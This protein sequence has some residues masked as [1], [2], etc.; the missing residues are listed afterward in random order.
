MSMEAVVQFWQTVERTP[1]LKK[2]VLLGNTVIKFEQLSL[3][4]NEAGF[5]CTQDELRAADNVTRFWNRVLQDKTLQRELMPAEELSKDKAVNFIHSVAT[6]AGFECSVAQFDLI[7]K[8]QAHH[9]RS[10][11]HEELNDRQLEAVAGGNIVYQMPTMSPLTSGFQS[12]NPAF[13][14]LTQY[15]V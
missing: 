2:Q 13:S 10:E 8:A 14:S 3:I 12:F 4:A 9:P 7:T 15:Y 1:S 6:K 11:S 5:K